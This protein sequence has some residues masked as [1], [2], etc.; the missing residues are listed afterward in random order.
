MLPEYLI[1]LHLPEA[2]RWRHVVRA[3]GAAARR[4][5]Q[6]AVG[7]LESVPAVGHWFFGR[8]Y[9]LT[10]GLYWDEMAAW[11]AHFGLDADTVCLLNCLYEL[12]HVRLRHFTLGLLGCTA[13]VHWNPA[14]GMVHVRNLDWPLKRIG[15]ASCR[16]RFRRGRREFVAVGMAGQVGILSGMLPGRYSVTLNWAPPAQRPRFSFGPT[17]LLRHALETCDTYEEIVTLLRATPLATSVFYVVCGAQ[18]GEGCVIERTPDA[19][20]LRRYES[21]PLTQTNHYIARRFHPFNAE[22]AIP[23]HPDAFVTLADSRQRMHVLAESL[24]TLGA[25]PELSRY[26]RALNLAP[27]LNADTA[28]QMVFCPASGEIRAWRRGSH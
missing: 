10:G 26:H 22:I 28:Q 16:F 9:R 24:A 12:S 2:R 11:A 23:P 21:E 19:A 5:A 6:E 15:P 14:H 27:V 17:F 13:G 8:W 4:L 7:Q 18:E 25:A 1:D 3:Q 20:V